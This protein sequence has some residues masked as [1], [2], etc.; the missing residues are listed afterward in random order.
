MLNVTLQSD[1]SSR[2]LSHSQ[3][4]IAE[5][6]NHLHTLTLIITQICQI[7]KYFKGGLTLSCHNKIQDRGN[8]WPHKMDPSPTKTTYPLF[9]VAYLKMFTLFNQ[10]KIKRTKKA[11]YLAVIVFYEV[12]NNGCGYHVICTDVS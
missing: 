6:P 1:T 10:S 3:A 9:L 11:V 2:M 7:F 12:F 5:A 4:N 8:Q